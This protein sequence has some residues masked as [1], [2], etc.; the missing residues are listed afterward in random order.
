[1]R[2]CQHSDFI[3]FSFF[4][5]LFGALKNFLFIYLIGGKFLYNFVLAM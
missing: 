2:P 1:M 4:V 5:C 3:L